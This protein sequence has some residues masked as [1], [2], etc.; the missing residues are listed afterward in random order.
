MVPQQRKALSQA[1]EQVAGLSWF[2]STNKE[3]IMKRHPFLSIAAVLAAS[4]LAWQAQSI[5]AGNTASTTGAAQD[6]QGLPGVELDVGSNASDRGLPGVEMNIGRDGD[7][8]NVD[9]RTLGAGADMGSATGNSAD[10]NQGPS[11]VRPLRSDRG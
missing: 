9:T 7:Q 5:A 1:L 10:M 11:T 3:P 6:Q 8:N 4:T 2:R